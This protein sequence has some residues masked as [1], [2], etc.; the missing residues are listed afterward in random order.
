ML[1]I[2]RF[3][4]VSGLDVLWHA[5]DPPRRAR[6]MPAGMS[7]RGPGHSNK[8]QDIILKRND[9]I[10]TEHDINLPQIAQ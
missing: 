4:F 6:V 3:A 1:S 5:E 7:W 2:W 10:F 9:S 8:Q